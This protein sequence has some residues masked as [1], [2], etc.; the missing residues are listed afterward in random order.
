MSE[1]CEA[2]VEALALL[3]MTDIEAR[4]IRSIDGSVW[5]CVQPLQI[6]TQRSGWSYASL[7]TIKYKSSKTLLSGA[8]RILDRRMQDENYLHIPEGEFDINIRGR[9]F[10]GRRVLDIP[11][12]V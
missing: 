2:I 5:L 3:K 4:A 12:T 1:K 6:W 9:E 8:K 11:I 7:A 10:L